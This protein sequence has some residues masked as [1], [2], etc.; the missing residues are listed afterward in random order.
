MWK[1][2]SDILFLAENMPDNESAV[3]YIRAS[4]REEFGKTES[5]KRN[6]E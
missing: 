3:S 1:K 5:F 2:L 4:L 6:F